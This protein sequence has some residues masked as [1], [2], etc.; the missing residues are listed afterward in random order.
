MIGTDLETGQYVAIKYV[1]A[2]VRI[3]C[4]IGEN[5]LEQALNPALR[6]EGTS[7]TPVR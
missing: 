5:L 4:P 3:L 1:R 2:D 7:N 6:S